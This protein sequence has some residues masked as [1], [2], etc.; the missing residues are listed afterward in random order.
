MIREF[1]NSDAEAIFVIVNENW[2]TVYSG[3]VDPALVS[4]MG[5]MLRNG[6]LAE[7]V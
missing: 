4:H 7:P 1:E 5:C 2:R 6:E 3:Y